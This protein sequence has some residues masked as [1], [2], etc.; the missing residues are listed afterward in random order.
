M[1]VEL[2]VVVQVLQVEVVLV[3]V[4][5]LLAVIMEK[6]AVVKEDLQVQMDQVD[7]LILDINLNLL[8][9]V[10]MVE[11]AVVQDIFPLEQ[12]MEGDMEEMVQCV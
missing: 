6:V 12:L 11:V 4:V 5:V 10:Y 1:L 3:M 7:H 9:L 8:W 2:L